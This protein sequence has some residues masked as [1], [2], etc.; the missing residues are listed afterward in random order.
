MEVRGKP[1]GGSAILQVHTK[2]RVY[3]GKIPKVIVADKE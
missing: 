2:E 3:L 1:L